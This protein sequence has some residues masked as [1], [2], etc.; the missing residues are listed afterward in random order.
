MFVGLR[1][2]FNICLLILYFLGVAETGKVLAGFNP[3]CANAASTLGELYMLT[4]GIHKN[5]GQ[6]NNKTIF[7]LH[8]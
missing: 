6:Q 4:S 3:N 2:S 8:E 1:Y 7:Y 5:K